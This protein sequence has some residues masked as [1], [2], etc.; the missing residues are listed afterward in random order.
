MRGQRLVSVIHAYSKS[1]FLPESKSI[2]K[3][4]RNREKEIKRFAKIIISSIT[5]PKQYVAKTR[6]Q[7]INTVFF[8]LG[9]RKEK[10]HFYRRTLS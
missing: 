6:S 4:E 5:I 8:L 7:C 3:I 9:I 2:D 10:I 1:C